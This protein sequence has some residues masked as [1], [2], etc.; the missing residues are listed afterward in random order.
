MKPANKLIRFAVMLVL[1]VVAIPVLAQSENKNVI[2]SV[3]DIRDLT[4]PFTVKAF[5][6]GNRDIIRAVSDGAQK[7]TVTALK[8]GN[9]DLKV[10][11][12]GDE[13]ATFKIT[14]GS[15]LEAVL[16][17]LRK[18]LDNIPGVEAEVGLGKVVLRGIITKPRDWSYLKKTVLPT[19]GDQVQCKVQFKLQDEML[20]KL[21]NDLQKNR[22][23]VQ[24]G[25]DTTPPEGTLN[26]FTTDNNV[27][28][29]GSVFSQGDLQ[30]I[31]S[32]INSCAWLTV[33]KEGDKV[34]D[35]ACY[36]VV[37]VSITPVL[38]EM[39][40]CFVGVTDSEALK[41][42]ANLLKN[43]LGTIN[44][45]AGISGN[46]IHGTP[47]TTK[48]TYAVSANIGDTI[49]ALGG[50]QGI[51]PTR[52]SS[53]GHL[54]FRNDA[55]DWKT[56]KD[57]GTVYIEATGGVGSTATVVPVEYGYIIKAKGGLSDAE[58]AALDMNV[59]LSVPVPKAGRFELKQNRMEASI[60]CPIGKTLILGGHKEL[61]EGV[62]ITSETPILGKVPGLQFLFSERD[63]NKAQRQVLTLVSVQLN[64]APK[65][66]A[67]VS[68]Q[69]AD[70]EEKSAKPLNILKPGLK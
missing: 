38:L 34:E 62:Q 52:F 17:E 44:V 60:S 18:D 11:G 46:M 63:K 50:G 23:K 55:T 26:L 56:Y 69:T 9:T 61:T 45:L 35:D 58:T 49:N 65:A 68:D 36:A 7:L 20:L 21:K 13:T 27:F 1:L 66:S 22:F 47:D 43:G 14:I 64:K 3:G 6:P 31:K 19:Y 32:V 57:G 5:E 10:I 53:I 39:D 15:S 29:N 70:T 2:I 33:R 30:T 41:L 4:V 28:I 25:N 67:P 51:G 54:T 24:E 16:A 42:G 37:N 8:E 59:E 12:T 40:V 48:N